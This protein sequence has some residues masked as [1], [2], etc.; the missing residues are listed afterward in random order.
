[1][2]SFAI[3][4]AAVTL[5]AFFF[6]RK[7]RKK[8]PNA[9]RFSQTISHFILR[10]HYISIV[11]VVTLIVLSFF[12][13]TPRGTWTGHLIVITFLLTG[14]LIY[15]VG[16]TRLNRGEKPYFA[17]MG[18]VPLVAALFLCIPFLGAVIELS[19][20][21]QL[22]DS[23][24]VYYS[25]STFEVHG[26]FLGV[27][28]RPHCELVKKEG[29]FDRFIAL[30]DGVLPGDTVIVQRLPYVVYVIRTGANYGSDTL[31]TVSGDVLD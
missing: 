19:L 4:L 28:G 30:G 5:S 20:V 11:L 14:F 17:F 26:K 25:D 21:G 8:D 31:L 10:I 24:K 9:F 15:P 23:H 6:V 27:L 7:R 13:L 18:Y 12:D 29:L 1:M 2:L 3:A 22:L 16:A